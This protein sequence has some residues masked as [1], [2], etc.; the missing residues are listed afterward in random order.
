MESKFYPCLSQIEQGNVLVSETATDKFVADNASLNHK[1][2]RLDEDANDAFTCVR[3]NMTSNTAH[4]DMT[5][6]QDNETH[7][8]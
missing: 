1:L 5:K 7:Q 2:N 8:A 6:T 4:S 3:S